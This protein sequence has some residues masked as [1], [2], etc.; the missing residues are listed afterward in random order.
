MDFCWGKMVEQIFVFPEHIAALLQACPCS[1][2]EKKTSD[3]QIGLIG[4]FKNKHGQKCFPISLFLKKRKKASWFN[5]T[6]EKEDIENFKNKSVAEQK[7]TV[8]CQAFLSGPLSQAILTSLF[9]FQIY[10]ASLWAFGQSYLPCASST[11]QS[12]SPEVAIAV[13][14]QEPDF[15]PGQHSLSVGSVSVYTISSSKPLFSHNPSPRQIL[16]SPLQALWLPCWSLSYTALFT[17]RSYAR[18][19]LKER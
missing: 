11:Q 19:V 9:K 14:H 5:P 12:L 10:L 2:E 13:S 17:V 1:K 6:V 18:E 15:E 3:T 8:H 16:S 4:R 7:K